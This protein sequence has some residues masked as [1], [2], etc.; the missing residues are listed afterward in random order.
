MSSISTY[1]RDAMFTRINTL[2][3]WKSTRKAPAPT[4]QV[5]DVTALGVFLLRE[6]MNPDGDANTGPPRYIVDAFISV[7][8]VDLATDPEVLEG[9]VDAKID[10]IRDTLLRD[11]TFI[12]LRWT[13]GSAI[14]DSIPS[15]TRTY[16]FPTNGEAYFLE[17]RLQFQVRYFC[18]FDPIAP[19]ALLEVDVDTQPFDGTVSPAYTTSIP[20][21]Q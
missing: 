4:L 3:P 7:A 19:N 21:P 9:S 1:I 2:Y 8:V 17:C 14:I 12:D 6:T 5:S 18:Y 16:Q 20:L 15:I 11:H 13:D 10:N